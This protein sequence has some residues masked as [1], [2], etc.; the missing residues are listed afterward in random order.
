MRSPLAVGIDNH[1]V[2]VQ[3]ERKRNYKL[4]ETTKFDPPIGAD[5]I[6]VLHNGGALGGSVM[7]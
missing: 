4:R 3:K 1:M 7:N 5:C 6:N 2:D